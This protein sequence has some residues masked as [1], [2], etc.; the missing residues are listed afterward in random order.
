[1][2][3]KC[4]SFGRE[5]SADCHKELID[6]Q[7]T[8]SV[9][10]ERV[11]KSRDVFLG[12]TCLKI[13]ASFCKFLLRECL[14]AIIVHDLEEALDADDATSS[15]RLYLLTEEPDE[16]LRS[17]I[18]ILAGAIAFNCSLLLSELTNSLLWSLGR[19]AT[20]CLKNL[21]EF[22]IVNATITTPIVILEDHIH[23]LNAALKNNTS[24]VNV[25]RLLTIPSARTTPTF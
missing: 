7:C 12:D 14:G 5:L 22:L 8:I 17:D 2:L 3:D 24:K 4:K 9:G 20:T 19:S 15:S 1:M 16:G 25:N 13:A 6:V 18:A 11:E 10:V 23:V 21:G